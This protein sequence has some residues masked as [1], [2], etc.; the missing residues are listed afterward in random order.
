[1]PLRV[2]IVPDK[3]KGTLT[4][5]QAAK[6]IARGWSDV[7]PDDTLE[8][9]PMADGGEGFGE[10]LG[11]SLHARRITCS[12][13]DAARRPR[14]AAWWRAAG[15][16]AIVEAAQVNGLDLLPVGEYHPFQLDTYGLG[17]VLRAAE[18]ASARVVYVGIGGSATN[19]GG[20]GL[21][22]ALGWRF[23]DASGD[24]LCV[25][26]ELDRLTELRAPTRQL[27]FG[28]VIIAVDVAN[29]LLGE[30][31][32]TRVYGPQ[33]GLLGADLLKAEACLRRLAEV[34][35]AAS[36][37]GC[38]DDAGAGAAGGLGF[39]LRAF[40]GGSFESGARIFARLAGFEPKIRDAD[41]VITGEGALDAQSLMGKGVG[42]VVEAAAR[43]GKRCFCLAG[44]VALDPSS[45]HWP[46]FRTFAIVPDV[47]DLEHAKTH[48]EAC[49]RE[50]AARAASA[51]GLS[52]ARDALKPDGRG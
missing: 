27:S 52:H 20:F 51:V 41:L 9:L 18:D 35:R 12:T 19:D 2:L 25:W 21:A 24:A 40:V 4:A 43:A 46:K 16:V 3:F 15:D 5:P 8:E 31:G 6:A 13:V 29:P 45:L 36:L 26:T 34:T 32:A 49:L 14:A 33:K 11:A 22:R 1:M 28:A 47:A 50:L 7:R 42:L 30:R 39:G 17:A 37:G 10:L 48:S 38:A 23:L 44:T